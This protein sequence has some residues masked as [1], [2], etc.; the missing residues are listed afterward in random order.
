MEKMIL[1]IVVVVLPLV[2]RVF[3]EVVVLVAIT[4]EDKAIS[5]L[6]KFGGPLLF[7]TSQASM[8]LSVPRRIRMPA[9]ETIIILNSAKIHQTSWMIMIIIIT[10]NKEKHIV[11]GYKSWVTVILR[12]ER[13]SCPASPA[14]GTQR[15][16]TG[17]SRTTTITIVPCAMRRPTRE[18]KPASVAVAPTNQRNG[19]GGR[20]PRVPRCM[21][22]M[23]T[24]AGQQRASARRTPIIIIF[25][26]RAVLCPF[27]PVPPRAGVR[28]RRRQWGILMLLFHQ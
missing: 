11:N 7:V 4:R 2:K 14:R 1:I 16:A 12:R 15:K 13:R 18:V 17:S 9:K 27:P 5:N 3:V 22:W 19:S 23:R 25:T 28:R 6:P 20:S 26:R 10:D 21:R 24:M 8:P